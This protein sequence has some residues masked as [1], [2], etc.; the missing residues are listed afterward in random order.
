MRQQCQSVL[1]RAEEIKALQ[2]NL[3]DKR[4]ED[5]KKKKKD[6]RKEA[7]QEDVSSLRAQ[8]EDV[9]VREKPD[10]SWDDVVG[11]EDAKAAMQ[12]AIVLP[13]KYPQLFTGKRKPPSGILLFGVRLIS[14]RWVFG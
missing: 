1:R 11:M 3:S 9:I 13:T 4:K 5:K 6:G 2:S 8:L 12:E 14:C 10:V 7:D